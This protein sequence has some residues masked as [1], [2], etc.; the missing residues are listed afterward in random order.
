MATT[1]SNVSNLLDFVDQYVGALPKGTY[2]NEELTTARRLG[3]SLATRLMTEMITRYGNVSGYSVRKQETFG[4]VDID[5]SSTVN[6]NNLVT[7]LNGTFHIHRG[8]IISAVTSLIKTYLSTSHKFA[9][10]ESVDKAAELGEHPKGW[11]MWQG[12]TVESYIDDVLNPST[13]TVDLVHL[14][15]GRYRTPDGRIVCLVDANEAEKMQRQ[16]Q[17]ETLFD[18]NSDFQDAFNKITEP[19]DN[20]VT[21]EDVAQY[22]SEELGHL[23]GADTALEMCRQIVDGRATVTITHRYDEKTAKGSAHYVISGEVELP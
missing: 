10:N 23:Y 20:K 17:Q 4:R 21:N 8:T 14:G 7:T 15:Y 22:L 18:T 2:T 11:S 6:R 13:H 9:D 16:K 1:P 12:E 19:V 3:K 5:K